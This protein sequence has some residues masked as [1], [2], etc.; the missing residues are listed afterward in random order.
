MCLISKQNLY[1]VCKEKMVMLDFL[2]KKPAE[3]KLVCQVC[4]GNLGKKP[5]SMK[6]NEYRFC[7][8]KCLD[9][10][11]KSEEKGICEFC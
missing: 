11:K 1:K 2:K 8:K 4:K 3:K 7:S 5:L 10:F 6:G 9:R